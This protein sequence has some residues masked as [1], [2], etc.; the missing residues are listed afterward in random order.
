MS[1][2]ATEG[3]GPSREVGR[4]T[5]QPAEGPVVR[6]ARYE[7]CES[8]HP[9]A[10]GRAAARVPAG[11][12]AQDR[13]RWGA[14]LVATRSGASARARRDAH[15]GCQDR[16]SPQGSRDKSGDVRQA[17]ETSNAQVGGDPSD[18]AAECNSQ[19]AR[20]AGERGPG[21]RQREWQSGGRE[22][23]GHSPRRGRH[24]APRTRKHARVEDSEGN[25]EGGAKRHES[26]EAQGRSGRSKGALVNV[27]TPMDRHGRLVGG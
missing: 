26:P 10:R 19:G 21:S 23:G 11:P 9:R 20:A 13:E 25:P 8:G 16:A 15:G 27:H 5:Q 7:M 1:R 3:P 22:R 18:R 24:M 14:G 4:P 2:G 6:G 17:S 12:A